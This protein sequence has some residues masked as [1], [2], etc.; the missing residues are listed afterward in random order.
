[1][2][3]Q[4]FAL[5][6]LLL[7]PLVAAYS[8]GSTLYPWPSDFSFY[9]LASWSQPLVASGTALPADAN[10]HPG[11]LFINTATST[12]PTL[13]RRGTTTWHLMSGAS[14][15]GDG[16][17]TH[18]LLIGLS[19]AD[20][21]HTGFNSAASHTLHLEDQTDPHGASMTVSE[22][23]TIGSGTPDC[24]IYRVATG[25]IG[26]AT[27]VY[28][29]GKVGIGTSTPQVALHVAD[30]GVE[31]I[32][33]A[34]SGTTVF[35]PLTVFN[36]AST[37][38][39]LESST[40]RT[41]IFHSPIS[42]TSDTPVVLD[43]DTGATNAIFTINVDAVSYTGGSCYHAHYVGRGYLFPSGYGISENALSQN[44]LTVALSYVNSTTVR[45]TITDTV[46]ATG[47]AGVA[48]IIVTA[49]KQ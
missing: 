17:S 35:T 24:D 29:V 28:V 10:A 37:P 31:C 48:R 2:K 5:F 1:M 20:S 49:V 6:I 7:V 15:S 4:L 3:K 30:G 47:K 14:T 33:V 38:I 42:T 27:D 34:S 13:W 11:D 16:V 22:K 8:G 44:G 32:R 41:R 46:S 40:T 21:G 18:S 12:A 25:V 23:V 26:L 43:V 9:G 45:V 39:S 36:A 19:F